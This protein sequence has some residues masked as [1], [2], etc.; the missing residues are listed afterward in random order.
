MGSEMDVSNFY[1]VAI[2]EA[3]HSLNQSSGSPPLLRALY[4]SRDSSDTSSATVKSK[5]P[6]FCCWFGKAL[7]FKGEDKPVGGSLAAAEADL[8]SKALAGHWNKLVF[9]AVPFIVCYGAAGPFLQFYM[10][11]RDATVLHP[12]FT[13][14]NMHKVGQGVCCVSKYSLHI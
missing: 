2:D 8:T 7:L 12:I 4:T 5:R 6:D 10:I 14:L 11:Q 1:N 13:M 3:L 9:G